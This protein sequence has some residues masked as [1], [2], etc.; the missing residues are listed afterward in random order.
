MYIH[1]YIIHTYILKMYIDNLETKGQ[2]KEESKN[3]L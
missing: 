3:N 2:Y 1:T